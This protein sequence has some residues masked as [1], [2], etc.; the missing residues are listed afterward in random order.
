MLRA[1]YIL[2]LNLHPGNF[3]QRFGAEMLEVF[4]DAP[5]RAGRILLIGDGLVSLL[6][7]WLL[8]TEYRRPVQP[9]LVYEA[10]GGSFPRFRTLDHVPLRRPAVFGGAGLAA[11]AFGLI[12]ALIGREGYQQSLLLGAYHP[13]PGLL[14]VA[15]SSFEENLN[16]RVQFA[17]PPEDP[18]NGIAAVYFKVVRALGVLDA[19]KDLVISPWEIFTAPAGLRRLDGNHDGKLSAE[20]LGFSLGS[21]SM[22]EEFAHRSRLAFMRENP[23]LAVLDENHDGELSTAEIANSFRTLTALDRNGDGSLTPD[24][25]IPDQ[26]I[27]RSA[28][29]F[30]ALDA[31]GDGFISREERNNRNESSL[32]NLLENADRNQDGYVTLGEFKTE[33]LLRI[34]H[35]HQLDAARRRGIR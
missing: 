25:V 34:E 27:A 4:E 23:A 28:T 12:A 6:R 14:S 5:A 22:S 16:A 19:N 9:R 3:R 1:I 11:I 24:E 26:Q 31:N 10:G 33:Y 13:R 15:R 17:H 8:R 20:E 30:M 35:K 29:L 21:N 2:L 7:Q 32:Q 18:L